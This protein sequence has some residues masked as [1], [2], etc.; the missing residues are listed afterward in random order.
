MSRTIRTNIQCENL[1]PLAKLTEEINSGALKIAVL[2]NNGSGKTFISRIFRLLEKNPPPIISSNRKVETDRLISFDKNSCKFSFKVTEIN[3]TVPTVKEDISFTINKGIIPT[4]PPT[5]YI[6]HCFNE[7][8]V[9]QNIQTLSF[10]KDSNVVGYILGKINIDVSNEEAELKSKKESKTSLTEKTKSEIIKYIDEKIGK[11]PNIKKL[12]EFGYLTFE[13]IS[14]GLNDPWTDFAKSYDELISDYNKIKS[15]PENLTD[16]K[17]I[18]QFSYERSIFQEITETLEK[19]F[20]LGLFAEDFKQKVRLKQEFIETGLSLIYDNVCPFCEQQLTDAALNLIDQY[21]K[22][23][24]DQE[25]QTI[26]LLNNYKD[27]LISISKLSKSTS[28]EINKSAKD[29][30]DYKTKYIPSIEKVELALIDTEKLEKEFDVLTIAINKKITN[31]SNPIPLNKSNLEKIYSELESISNT[32]VE[33]NKKIQDINNKKNSIGE[34]NKAVRRNLCKVVFNNLIVAHRTNVESISKLDG[35]ILKLESEIKIKKEQQKISKKD[36]VAST[37]KSVLKFFFSEK[38][39][40]DEKSFRLVLNKKILNEGQAKEVLSAGEK[41]VIAFAYYLGDVHLKIESEDDYSKLF[42]IIDDPISS[43]DFNHVY[44]LCGVLRNLKD[45]IN[46]ERDRFII[47]THNIEFMRVLV[48]NNIATKSLVLKNGE[49]AEF[50]NNL[51]VPYINHLL[52]IY[53]VSKRKIKPTHTTP[54]SIRHVIETLSKFE[55]LKDSTDSI[56]KFIKDFIPD[57]SKTYT[58][59][60]DLSHGGWR[61]EQA[62]IHEDDFVDVCSS[63]IEMVDK[64][65]KGQITYCTTLT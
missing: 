36:K 51:T 58:L 17:T 19:Q 30:N 50:N 34:E 56:D 18:T 10:D 45:I 20:S 39:T 53:R 16:I 38:Y 55:N 27:R 65:Y 49:I 28:N 43:M 60:Q 59:I 12:N 63:I 33:N 14:A 29:F 5:N 23:V 24:Q 48:G 6:Y 61:T 9:E 44:S 8:Y 25:A 2:A 15:V 52:D 57:D 11:I 7:D 1:A 3:D 4:L 31:I 42:L 32:V 40:L 41:N 21:N 62:P 22:F 35:E 64:K 13:N 54:N 26:K 46:N 37:V 47:F